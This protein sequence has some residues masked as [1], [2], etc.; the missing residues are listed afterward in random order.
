MIAVPLNSLSSVWSV[1]S[2]VN[3]IKT[4]QRPAE[5]GRVATNH[6]SVISVS[7]SI[8]LTSIYS[9]IKRCLRATTR[10]FDILWTTVSGCFHKML[11]NVK[12]TFEN[13]ISNYRKKIFNKV[14]ENLVTP[15]DDA[16]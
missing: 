12:Q 8:A 10:T 3:L 6:V 2:R 13:L 5:R 15:L 11:V 14:T 9:A 4:Q 16:T 7:Q 1:M